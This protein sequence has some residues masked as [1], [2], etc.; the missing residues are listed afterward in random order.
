[1]LDMQGVCGCRHRSDLLGCALLVVFFGC[2]R[3]RNGLFCLAPVRPVWNFHGYRSPCRMWML[4]YYNILVQTGRIFLSRLHQN[5]CVGRK[6][7]QLSSISGTQC[8]AVQMAYFHNAMSMLTVRYTSLRLSLSLWIDRN[9]QPRFPNLTHQTS[10]WIHWNHI[11][12]F[13][14][15]FRGNQWLKM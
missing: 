5:G 10:H 8:C 7:Q 14:V 4:S 13:L 12:M 15:W 6:L 3:R 2:I 1:M 9:E 11:S